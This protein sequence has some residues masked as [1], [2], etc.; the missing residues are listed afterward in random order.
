MSIATAFAGV[1]TDPAQRR[2][3]L[4]QRRLWRMLDVLQR[5]FQ[6]AGGQAFVVREAYVARMLNL[7]DI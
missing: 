2:F 1:L 4:H 7:I 6:G 5:N 3:R